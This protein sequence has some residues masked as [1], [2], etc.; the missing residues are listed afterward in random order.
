MPLS[1]YFEDEESDREGSSS[2]LFPEA[3]PP[4]IPFT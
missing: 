2:L 3:P 1:D 4:I